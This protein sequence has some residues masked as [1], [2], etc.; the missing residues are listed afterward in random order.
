[1]LLADGHLC[2]CLCICLCIQE[3]SS[4]P[5][6]DAYCVF[7]VV[8]QDLPLLMVSDTVLTFCFARISDEKAAIRHKTLECLG[9]LSQCF[10]KQICDLFIKKLHAVKS[11]QDARTYTFFQRVS[12]RCHAK[13]RM[14]TDNGASQIVDELCCF[15]SIVLRFPLFSRPFAFCF[16]AIKNFAFGVSTPSQAATTMQYL[17]SLRQAMSSVERGVLRQEMCESLKA[18]YTKILDRSEC[19]EMP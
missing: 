14:K 12:E 5:S 15:V 10:L 18:I 3:C 2:I 19:C 4:A 9:V 6:V 1:M 16:Q 8:L 11:E 7:S 13:K 17:A